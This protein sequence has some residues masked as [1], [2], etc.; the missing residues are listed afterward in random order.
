MKSSKFLLLLILL[1]SCLP[2]RSQSVEPATIEISFFGNENFSNDELVADFKGCYGHL[3]QKYDERAYNFIAQKCTRALMQSK[4]F[5]KANV[6]DISSTV[7]GGVRAVQIV[8]EEGRRYRI[9]KIVIEG[10][11]VLSKDEILE[12]WG[13]RSGDVADGPRLLYLAYEK[14]KERYGELGYVQYS[15]E[16]DPDFVE[17]RGRRQDGVVNVTITIDEGR[18][19]RVGRV[20]F[21]GVSDEEKVSL[22]AEFALKAGNMFTPKGLHS[23][24]E[25][26]NETAR[27]EPVDVDRDID[28]LTDEEAP[29]V[30]VVITVRRPVR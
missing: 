7:R 29:D 2:L 23:A 20:E 17:P 18:K 16:F 30:D 3:W 9:G 26:L 27:F 28:I 1:Y 15:A 19:F 21:R 22:Q 5:W 24:V 6:I 4:G 14:L 12:L 25:I 10:N 11:E 13:Q 8:V